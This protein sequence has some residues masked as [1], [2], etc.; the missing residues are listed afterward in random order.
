GAWSRD[1]RRMWIVARRKDHPRL[2]LFPVDLATRKLLEP[3]AG[4]DGLT[5]PLAI[6]PDDQW[7]AAPGADS[8]VTVYP[9]KRGE[10]VKISSVQADVSPQPAGWTSTGELWIVLRGATPP[11]LVRVHFPGGKI[12]RS[13][14]LD[15]RQ[16]GGGEITDA[17]ITPDE[18]L[19]AV[20]YMD[21]RGR[22]ELVK[23]IPADR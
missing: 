13:I 17:R 10:P 8:A 23:G 3:I 22:L 1:G 11:R 15:L 21:F 19:L 20:E 16:L 9:V 7:I 2:Q 6:S 5:G 14:D 18:S 12:T 4:S